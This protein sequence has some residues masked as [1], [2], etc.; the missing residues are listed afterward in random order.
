MLITHSRAN[1]ALTLTKLVLRTEDLIS[2]LLDGLEVFLD[3]CVMSWHSSKLQMAGDAIYIGLQVV[4]PLLQRS[5]K[6]CVPS[7]EPM[8]LHRVASVH[9][10]TLRPEVA[11][12][13]SD[14]V[15]AVPGTIG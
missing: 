10:V 15:A 12:G 3:V 7:D 13:F 2:M 5:A 1:L 9:P 14:T 6:I 8:P 11:V 4:E